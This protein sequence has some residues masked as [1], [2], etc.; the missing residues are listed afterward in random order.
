[1]QTAFT[2]EVDDIDDA[3]DELLGQ[4]DFD[5]LKQ[6]SL[7][8][9]SCYFDFI[10]TEVYQ[11]VAAKLPFDVVG[12]TSMASATGGSAGQFRLDLTI[13]TSDDVRFATA[14][15]PIIDPS[16]YQDKIDVAYKEARAKLSQDP[17]MIIAYFPPRCEISGSEL[18]TALDTSGNGLPIFGSLSSGIDMGYNGCRVFV[19]DQ[20]IDN[21]AAI[22]L[23]EGDFQPSFSVTHIPEKNIRDGRFVATGTDGC[24]LKTIN[25]VPAEEYLKGLG[26]TLNADN[27]TTMPFLLYANNSAHPVA[28]GI[29]QM[30][31]D[32][33][34]LFGA[35]IPEGSSMALGEIDAEGIIS[36]GQDN[37]SRLLSGGD[38]NGV[39]CYPCVSRYI[40]LA[41]NQNSEME[42]LIELIANKVPYAITYSGGEICP[43][44]NSE[45]K[46]VN[47]FHNYS[48]P[49]M[50]F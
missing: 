44:K 28:T 40:M 7:G 35:P 21:A 1:M 39:L 27:M 47:Q 11:Q 31:P 48:F 10:E 5:S 36:T 38:V 34:M 16:N 22:A 30:Y 24:I 3:L 4:I 13:L 46:W 17:A 15:T 33:S 19:N 45:G 43:V 8:V 42:Q 18:L 41:P 50:A 20:V 32:G 12:M 37:I 6:N 2:V 9:M 49:L 23:L 14:I 29:Y 25:D 26:L